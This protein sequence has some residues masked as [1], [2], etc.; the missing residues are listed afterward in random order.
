MDLQTAPAPVVPVGDLILGRDG[1]L[2]SLREGYEPRRPQIEMA[3]LIE[4]ALGSNAHAL[5][6]AGT[7]TGKSYAYLIPAIISAVRDGKR[8][9]VST[10]TIQLQEQ[11]VGKD[12]PF[13]A[14]VLSKE[15]GR[16]VRYAMAKG[17]S[18]YFCERNASEFVDEGKGLFSSPD[19]A[20][21]GRLL[22]VFKAGNWNGD[23]ASLK[24]PVLPGQWM[25]AN[26]EESC[27]GRSC[28]FAGRCG[29][30]AAKS[31]REQADIVVTNHTMYLL[32]CYL[33]RRGASI[34]PEHT[35]WIADEAHTLA[36]KAA[37]T[38]GVTLPHHQPARFLKRLKRQAGL[39]KLDIGDIPDKEVSQAAD[40]FFG[41]F[42]GSDRDEMRLSDFAEEVMTLAAERVQKLVAL[43]API[44]LDL[45]Q[46]AEAVRRGQIMSEM[47][48]EEK[49]KLQALSRLR[50]SVDQL[51][52][53]LEVF[54]E[55]PNPDYVMYAEVSNRGVSGIDVTLHRKPIET[56]WI[57]R[58]I[59]NQL[60]S[61]IF[62]SATLATGVGNSAWK[63]ALY[64]FGLEAGETLTMQAESPFD[65]ARQVRGYVPS[66]L[67]EV[68]SPEYHTG[69]AD[70]IAT[71]LTHTH[72]RA[73]VLFTS[74][75]D[76]HKVADLV[77]AVVRFPVL[78]QG[79]RQKDLLIEDFKGTPNSVLFGVKTFW[80]GVDIPGDA[81]SCVILCKLPFP[82]PTAP[83]VKARCERIEA[84]G[85]NSFGEFML[86]RCI[87][88][89]KQGFG[90]L[91]RSNT[92]TGLFV[93]LDSRMR[94]ARYGRTIAGSL[95]TFP[96]QSHL[97]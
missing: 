81:L 96:C 33:S 73:F 9:I 11:L 28:G 53:N 90:R 36:D 17:R 49:D 45:H 50:D 47:S 35:V 97:G 25:A 86:P 7:G 12:L 67:P 56:A 68:R 44:R 74:I 40:L 52:E 66:N 43:L 15:L 85:G 65:Y 29:Y 62:C 88:D 31:E 80:T 83:L 26:G 27:P 21:I 71:I 91:I 57:F 19:R 46:A 63:T 60:D 58:G 41:T 1:I 79:D 94:T 76:M 72:G 84:R 14:E 70:E 24:I 8:V 5:I 39:L 4:E 92:D 42:H 32:H 30:L 69:L 95:P 87:R 75:R 38:F 78:V 51:I 82:N 89:V 6:E 2:A 10:D 64:E 18:H 59:L 13:L 23:E 3:N 61:A 54:F 48:D 16:P 34:L 55:E 93:V 22:E 37:E 20:V 77:R